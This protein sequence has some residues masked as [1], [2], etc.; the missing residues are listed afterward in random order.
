MREG[1][2][3]LRDAGDTTTFEGM[4]PDGPL[5]PFVTADENL[6]AAVDAAGVH[7]AEDGRARAHATQITTDGP[8]FALSNNVGTTA[9]GI[10]FYRIVKGQRGELDEDGLETDLFAGVGV[11]VARRRRGRRSCCWLVPSPASRSVALHHYWWGLLLARRRDRGA[12]ATPSR[13]A[14]GRGCRS[15]SAGS[16]SSAG[17]PSRATRATT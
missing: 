10:E 5:P 15:R 9:W 2:R 14:G 4:D 16:R 11:K 1:L 3:T 13:R 17:W 6:A 7:R 12:L 8:F